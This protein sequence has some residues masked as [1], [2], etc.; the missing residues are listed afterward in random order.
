MEYFVGIFGRGRA[1]LER[2]VE[3]KFFQ[4]GIL[5]SILINTLSMGI[6]YH[7]QVRYLINP[8][9]SNGFSHTDKTNKDV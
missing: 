1:L 3:S 2:F 6:E 4:R 5:I 7:N 8:L 9:Y